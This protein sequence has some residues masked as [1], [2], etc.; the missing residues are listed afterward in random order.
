MIRNTI[1]TEIKNAMKSKDADRLYVLR[2]VK[3]AFS[4]FETSKGF[5]EEDF[6]EAKEASIIQKMHKSWTEERDAFKAAGRD[7]SELDRRLSIL[8]SF[9]PQKPSVSEIKAVMDSSG[10]EL[11][12]KNMGK[13]IKHVQSV[14]PSVTGKDISDIIKSGN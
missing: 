2:M 8:E 4:A 3:A 5:K 10:I 12:M 9:L 11:E 7:F 13:L 14:Y 1:N 6:N